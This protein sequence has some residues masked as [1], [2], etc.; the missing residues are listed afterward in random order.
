MVDN[1]LLLIGNE[2]SFMTNAIATGLE[3]EGF[4]VIK[5]GQVKESIEELE[6]KPDIYIMYLGDFTDE[7]DSNLLKYINEKI[8]KD[9]F[10]LYIVGNHD[11]LDLAAEYI[12][13]EKIQEEYLR[14][15]DVGMLAEDLKAA[16]EG[17]SI[18]DS[19]RKKILVVDDDGTLLRMIR[20]WLSVRYRV[21]MANSG[22]IAL[23]FLKDNPV[24]LV[25]LDY[26][27]PMISGPEVLQQIRSNKDTRNT[28][29]MFLTAKDDKD[30]VV[31]VASL[32]PEKYLLKSMPKNQLLDSIREFFE[33]IDNS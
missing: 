3:K 28:P 19:Q 9:R 32:K 25:L 15:I 18:D 7:N 2:K 5:A 21:Y 33:R 24:D 6:D 13:K 14:P 26:A 4:T 8:D 29:V 27:M 16:A 17:I 20:T 11:E 22:K 23:S 30:S 10:H 31:Q 12:P 1:R